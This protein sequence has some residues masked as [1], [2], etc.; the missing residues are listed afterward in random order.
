MQFPEWTC[1]VGITRHRPSARPCAGGE[2][3][4]SDAAAYRALTKRRQLYWANIWITIFVEALIVG[5]D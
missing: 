4:G 1:D 3:F 2:R 5:M